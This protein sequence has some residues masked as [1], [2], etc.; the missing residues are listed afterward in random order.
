MAVRHVLA[1]DLGTGGPKVAL[2]GLDGRVAG[3]E[4]EAI[5]LQRL[6]GGGVEQSP[7][8]WWQAIGTAAR[9]AAAPRAAGGD[10]VA[11]T[12]Q[13]AGTVAVGDDGEPLAPALSWLDSRGAPHAQRLAGG[14]VAGYAP[15]KVARWL[16]L[17]GGAPSL[18]GR[19][20]LGH[21]LYLKH[22]QP[23][24]YARTAVFLEPIDW[25]GL[26]LTGT[27]RG[28]Q[29]QRHAALADRHARPRARA[30]RR[31]AAAAGRRRAREAAR[32]AAR[33]RR[34]RRVTPAAAADLGIGAGVPVVAGSPDTM[35]AA[36][37]S[38]AVEDYAAH[39]YVGTSSWISC[40]VPFKRTDAL[41]SIASLPAAL[42]GR[43]IVSCEQQT[44]GAS[45]EQ[46]RA[47]LFGTAPAEEGYARSSSSPPRRRPA[48][49]G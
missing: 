23:D 28:H 22:E 10:A 16:R 12:G 24:L 41:H 4:Q 2:V 33:Q 21:V 11:V 48:P 42:P 44:A 34:A 43:Y 35:S 45:V 15:L 5:G 32:A 47:A 3:A 13:W 14:P 29:R 26:K 39:L 25:L 9:A 18:S 49:A 17:T 20:S 46:L 31:R 6:P 40:H 1:I 7:A 30:L 36:V 38:G 27:R 19:D 37:G 8:D